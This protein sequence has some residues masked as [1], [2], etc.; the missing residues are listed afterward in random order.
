[1]ENNP[2]ALIQTH[3]EYIKAGAECISTASYQASIKG[4]IEIGHSHKTAR[5]LIMKS[6]RLAEIAIERANDL[7]LIPKRP[8]IAGSIGP[9]GAY[10]ADGSE[11][12]GNYGLSDSELKDFHLE[13]IHILDQSNVD[14]LAFETIPSQHEA[15]IFSE[16]LVDAKT[17]SWISFSC[18]DGK[19]LND[20]S[21]IS[22]C[23]TLFKDHPTVFAIGANCTHPK[24]ITEIIKSI[25]QADIGKKIVVYPNS[26]EA[27]NAKTKKWIG[28]SE[29]IS[30]VEMAKE[31]ISTGAD[32]IGGCCRIGPEHIRSINDK[33]V[34]H[35]INE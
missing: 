12:R 28:L 20:G 33:A 21:K 1:M 27:Y 17:P 34:I 23:V 25:K 6:V 15:R 13:R 32:I 18:K 10:L 4:L 3:L 5:E 14:L 24:F 31:W 35:R 11:Y 8:L 22:D 26:G 7:N 2:E 29:P 30:F 16:I 9:Y 19:H